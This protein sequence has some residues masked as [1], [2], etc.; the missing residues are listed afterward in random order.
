MF[1]LSHIPTDDT[2]DIIAQ[3]VS[4]LTIGVCTF[5]FS[6]LWLRSYLRRK[7]MKSWHNSLTLSVVFFLWGVDKIIDSITL[8]FY[9]IAYISLTIELLIAF[10]FLS[11]LISNIADKSLPIF[12]SAKQI[13]ELDIQHHEK[14]IHEFRITKML[15]NTND[16]QEQHKQ[17]Y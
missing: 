4:W 15:K 5:L 7:F 6:W 9:P 3:A 17:E 10:I 11:W 16:I 1:L 8:L 13:D 14:S 2:I 12:L